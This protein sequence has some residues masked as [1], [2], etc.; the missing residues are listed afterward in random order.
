[1]VNRSGKQQINMNTK[2]LFRRI[3][4]IT[5]TQMSKTDKYAQVSVSEGIKRHAD[6]G[7]VT[8]LAEFSQLNDKQVF[9]P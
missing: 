6:K 9:K 2:D 7:V 1:M 8:V 3:V 4:G 5:M